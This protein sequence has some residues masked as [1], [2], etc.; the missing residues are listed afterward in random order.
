M[1]DLLAGILAWLLAILPY[2]W[3]GEDLPTIFLVDERQVE[4]AAGGRDVIAVYKCD[5]NAII[6]SSKEKWVLV[7]EMVHYLQCINGVTDK[8][9][10]GILENEAYTVQDIW[11]VAKEPTAP[12]VDWFSVKAMTLECIYGP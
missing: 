3:H 12:R 10:Y 6:T 2:G 7:H 5:R 8:V 11:R 9:C 1:S 4:I